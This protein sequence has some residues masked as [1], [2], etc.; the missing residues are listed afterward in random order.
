[1]V[2]DAEVMHVHVAFATPRR[3]GSAVTRNRVRRQLR[4]LMRE[5]APRLPSGWY[6][7]GVQESPVDISW[8]QL[9]QMLDAALRQ[10]Q[11]QHHTLQATL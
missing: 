5:R 1:M 7:I 4:E 2:P 11:Q 10:A 3:L 9:G 6:L 8:G